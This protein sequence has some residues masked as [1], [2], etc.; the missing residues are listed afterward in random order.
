MFRTCLLVFLF[1]PT[2]VMGSDYTFS[3][4]RAGWEGDFTDYPVN[5]ESFYELAWGWE[6][7]P[8]PLLAPTGECL[9]KGL[10]LSGNNHS[11]DLFSFVRCKIG[12]LQ[13][14]A[15]YEI[16]VSVLIES[17]TPEGGV[18]I[19][20]A[21]GESVYFKIGASTEEPKKVAIDG[22]YSLNFDKGEQSQGGKEA[23]VVGNLAMPEVDPDH[24]RY[25]P[26]EFHTE[27]PLKVQSDQEGQLWLFLGAD[28]GF[29]G[30]TKFYIAQV[31]AQ[32]SVT[33][34]NP[35]FVSRPTPHF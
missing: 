29:E 1:L 10:F 28:S 14:N 31:R 18:G 19:G 13:P 21:P 4:D 2:F 11:D 32:I 12:E 8:T 35:E 33:T 24:P 23:V 7:L 5:Q 27:P 34:Q 6:N 16:D 30:R 26:K 17:N 9:E 25:C 22:F 20:G 15:W 3:K